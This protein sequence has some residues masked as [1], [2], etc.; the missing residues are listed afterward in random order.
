MQTLEYFPDPDETDE[1]T[2]QINLAI[3]RSLRDQR[4]RLA[5][6]TTKPSVREGVTKRMRLHENVNDDIDNE[7]DH[8]ED[9][10]YERF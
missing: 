9:G 6:P 8:I 7:D 5:A 2:R 10:D 1:E 4:K 3:E